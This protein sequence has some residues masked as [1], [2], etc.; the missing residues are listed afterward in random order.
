MKVLTT[1]TLRGSQKRLRAGYDPI[2]SGLPRV[3]AV[4]GH[5]FRNAPTIID[6]A[7]TRVDRNYGDGALNR[8]MTAIR[9]SFLP[10]CPHHA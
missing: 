3:A 4:A 7:I 2:A 9:A 1:I 8:A 6:F 5:S 10:K